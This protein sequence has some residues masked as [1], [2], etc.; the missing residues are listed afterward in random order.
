MELS[1]TIIVAYQ[2]SRFLL[3]PFLSIHD[4]RQSL[5][6]RERT[7]GRCKFVL[8]PIQICTYRT[9]KHPD[10]HGYQLRIEALEK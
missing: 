4:L 8:R 1:Q 10:L 6:A 2:A 7:L 3:V 5:S 9:Q